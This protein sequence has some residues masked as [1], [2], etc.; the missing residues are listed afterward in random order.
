MFCCCCVLGN[1]GD[2][3]CIGEANRAKT[4]FSHLSMACKTY[5][6]KSVDG[7]KEECFVFTH[8]QV[9]LSD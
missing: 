7:E 6:E 9:I 3:V 1:R 2:C 8:L 4:R 5:R